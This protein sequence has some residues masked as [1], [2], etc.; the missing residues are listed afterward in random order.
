[1]S[2]QKPITVMIVDDEDLAR[3]RIRDMLKND[4]EVEVVAEASTGVEAVSALIQLR[5]AILF[6]DIQMPGMDGFGVLKKLNENAMPMVIFVTAFDEFAIKAFE[7]HVCDYLLKP[8]KR[9]RFEEALAW[10]KAE[11]RNR[12]STEWAR[13]TCLLLESM[14]AKPVYI[15]RLP[16]KDQGKV[17]FVNVREIDWLEADDNYIRIHA[18]KTS[19]LI[20][21]TIRSIEKEL[22]PKC[23]VRIHRGAIINVERIKELQQWFGRDYRV[24]L[25][26]GTVLPL[27]RSYRQQLRSLLG[28]AF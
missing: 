14:N 7:F 15:E 8:F 6:L 2:E 17:F 28:S 11:L 24:V 1:M 9:K 21:G 13:R 25:R 12:N 16:I 23:F 26:D 5:P 19:H 10:A 4:P 3:E 18:A 22:D 27:G 20:R